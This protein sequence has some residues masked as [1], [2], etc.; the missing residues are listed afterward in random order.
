MAWRSARLPRRN[1]PADQ[2]PELESFHFFGNF[3]TVETDSIDR[4]PRTARE[5]LNWFSLT[6]HDP[7]VLPP[8]VG[9]HIDHL[10]ILGHLSTNDASQTR[11]RL[12][13]AGNQPQDR[14]IDFSR[15]ISFAFAFVLGG[16][17]LCLR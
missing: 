17:F 8:P 3:Q 12:W 15:P 9:S 2:Q 10:A 5:N 14:F 16:P 11:F 1:N 13:V 6:K 7:G 4:F